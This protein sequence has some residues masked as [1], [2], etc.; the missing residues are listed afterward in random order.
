[1][2]LG[3]H[4]STAGGIETSPE[5]AKAIGAD[6]LQIFSKNQKQWKAK[7]LQDQEVELFKKNLKQ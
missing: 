3:A 5:K 4:I 7:P 6:A 2:I 1:M